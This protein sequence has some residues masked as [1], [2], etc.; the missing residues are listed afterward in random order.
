M[1]RIKEKAM[2]KII[3]FKY[4]QRG[5]LDQFI[6]VVGLGIVAVLII[7]AL[8]KWAPDLAESIWDQLVE[9][10]RDIISIN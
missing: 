7:I 3:E 6:T 5:S 9:H 4:N 1:E 2:N 10:I 8:K